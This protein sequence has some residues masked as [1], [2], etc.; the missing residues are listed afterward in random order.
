MAVALV[1]AATGCSL[2]GD[3]EAQPASG[4]PVEVAELVDRLERATAEGD[5]A[6]LC[7]ELFTKD[8][9]ERAG[10][11]DCARLTRS[12]GGEV[13][14]PSIEILSIEVAGGRATVAIRTRAQGQAAVDETLQLRREGR[15]WRIEA[16][17][18]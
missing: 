12:A 18:S 8:A 14:R 16:L 6:T 5:Y 11:S 7:G 9:R 15:K 4:A 13:R 10:G 2:G 3:E 17:D 1:L